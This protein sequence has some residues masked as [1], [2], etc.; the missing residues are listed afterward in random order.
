[1]K[2][3]SLF[4]LLLLPLCA[5]AQ[6]PLSGKRLILEEA[7]CAGLEFQGSRQVLIY[8]EM[9]CARTGASTLRARIVELSPDTLLAVE[10]ADG[11]AAP[12]RPPRSWIYRIQSLSPQ[13][14][15]LQEIWTGWNALPDEIVRYRLAGAPTPPPPPPPSD[16]VF[17]RVESMV[18]GD[19]ACYLKL[20]DNQG[21]S[22]DKMADFGLCEQEQGLTGE[23]VRLEYA[24][25]RVPAASCQGDPE[26]SD[27]ERVPIIINAIPF[28]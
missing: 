9:T 15:T 11:D 1:M 24:T 13:H 12:D 17:Y 10:A 14:A 16:G 19:I 7:S 18:M 5:A 26:C 8:D 21:N 2:S 22:F 20:I 28:R 25:G 6:H 4:I 23:L 3:T 27:Y